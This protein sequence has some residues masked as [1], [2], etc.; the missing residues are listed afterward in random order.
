[1]TTMLDASTTAALVTALADYCTAEGAGVLAI[2]HDDA[3][4]THWADTVVHLDRTGA[5]PV[6]WGPLQANPDGG[7]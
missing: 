7:P 5:A 2:S 6:V 3:L 1:M 4:L